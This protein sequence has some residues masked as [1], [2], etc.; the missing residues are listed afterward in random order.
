MTKH[1]LD[2]KRNAEGSA[3]PAQF[4]RIETAGRPSDQS[5]LL[6]KKRQTTD[7]AALA[8]RFLDIERSKS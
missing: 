1:H 6:Q 7:T 5:R 4:M 2:H 3:R 8:K